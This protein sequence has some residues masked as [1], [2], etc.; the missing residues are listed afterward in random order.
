MV[1]H[2]YKKL[3]VVDLMPRIQQ[4]Q[5]SEELCDI[6]LSVEGRKFNAHKLMLAASSEYFSS[7]FLHS[8]NEK[9]NMAIMNIFWKT[10]GV[11]FIGTEWYTNHLIYFFSSNL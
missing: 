7:M 1:I 9:V 4:M 8:F 2:E 11:N 3:F 5:E 6:I 10:R